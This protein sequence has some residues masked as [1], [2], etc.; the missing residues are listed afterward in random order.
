MSFK[1]GQYRQ[2]IPGYEMVQ[3]VSRCASPL[4]YGHWKWWIV[5]NVLLGY[6]FE[7][8]E[9]SLAR[10]TFTEMEVLAICAKGK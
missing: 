10:R 9:R 6:T 5:R 3:L 1:E 8:S 2:H 4:G 7:C